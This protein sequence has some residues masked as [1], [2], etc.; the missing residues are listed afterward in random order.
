MLG[1]IW[2]KIII[3]CCLISDRGFRA[4]MFRAGDISVTEGDLKEE[5]VNAIDKPELLSVLSHLFLLRVLDRV[6]FYVWYG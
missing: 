3:V 1:C 4:W 6:C 2:L 5:R